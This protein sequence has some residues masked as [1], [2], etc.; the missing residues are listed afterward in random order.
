MKPIRI[1]KNDVFK[2]LDYRVNRS[3]KNLSPEHLDSS[4]FFNESIHVLKNIENFIDKVVNRT[5]S[6]LHTYEEAIKK[7]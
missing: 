2:T 5:I 1:T 6:S 3:V 7:K 4:L